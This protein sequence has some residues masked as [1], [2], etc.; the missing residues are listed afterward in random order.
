MGK[1]SQSKGRRGEI[2]VASI[3][4]SHGIPAEPGQAVSYGSTPDIVGVNGIHCEIKRRENVNLAAALAQAEEDSRKFGDGLPAVFHRRNRE[5]WRVTM[6]LQSWVELYKQ[7]FPGGF[8]R[9][10]PPGKEG[11][12]E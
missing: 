4:Q 2:E 7:A 11:G 3:L 9:S 6:P 1:S 8:G 10:E 12:I 5:S